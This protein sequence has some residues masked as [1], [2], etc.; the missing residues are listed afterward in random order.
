MNLNTP[1]EKDK[2][3]DLTCRNCRSGAGLRRSV[4]SLNYPR[5]LLRS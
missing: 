3:D 2:A 1:R 5:E 4:S